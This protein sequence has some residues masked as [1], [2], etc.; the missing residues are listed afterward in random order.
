L[1]VGTGRVVADTGLASSIA[2]GGEVAVR[3]CMSGE[4]VLMLKP[5]TRFKL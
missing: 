5:A 4:F 3:L 1:L 2:V